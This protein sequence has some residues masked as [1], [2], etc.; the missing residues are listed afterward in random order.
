MK[1]WTVYYDFEDSAD[2]LD[3]QSCKDF[4]EFKEN[5]EGRKLG[6]V[7]IHEREITF[8]TPEKEMTFSW[9]SNDEY[10]DYIGYTSFHSEGNF[11]VVENGI[12]YSEV[13]VKYD[14]RPK[15]VK[16]AMELIDTLRKDYYAQ[17]SA[18]E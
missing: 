4:V 12:E 14:L 8:F 3:E 5:Y 10:S 1:I 16:E 6:E 15:M 17:K 18:K 9:S 13:T 7:S 2:F 11:F